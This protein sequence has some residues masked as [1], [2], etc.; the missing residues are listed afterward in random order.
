[1]EELDHY[2]KQSEAQVAGLKP[3]LAKEIIW[4]DPSRKHRTSVSVIYLHG[5]SASRGETAPLMDRVAQRLGANLYYSRLTGHGLTD[6]DAFL[7]AHPQDWIDDAREALAIGRRIGQRV[8]IAGMSTG[9]ALALLLE[10]EHREAADIAGLVLLSPLL[11]SAHPL[12]K[13]VVGPLGAWWARIFIGSHRESSPENERHGYYWTNRYHSQAIV[14]LMGIVNRVR[15]LDLS[16]IRHPALVFY[17]RRDRVVS[18]RAIE[19]AFRRM[20]SKQKKL[21]HV[22][23]ATRHVLAG[24]ALSP[25]T[26]RFVEDEIVSFLKPLL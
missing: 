6:P 7:E 10:V 2:L 8:I 21:V 23:E 14:A 19:N 3:D 11:D 1:M 20:G 16:L 24:D 18:V 25:V 13:F 26:T 12:A 17:T 4:F 5:F 22:D 15:R 9:G